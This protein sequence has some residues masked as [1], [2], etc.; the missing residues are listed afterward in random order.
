[1]NTEHFNARLVAKHKDNRRMAL[2]SLNQSYIRL[3]RFHYPVIRLGLDT[4][5][6]IVVLFLNKP[7]KRMAALDILLLFYKYTFVFLSP[8]CIAVLF[9]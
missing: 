4:V 2:V 9:R 8:V 6:S 7:Q 1:M 3:Q 5:R